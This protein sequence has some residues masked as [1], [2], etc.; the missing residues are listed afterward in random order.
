MFHFVHLSVKI[1]LG[2]G[3]CDFT[4]HSKKGGDN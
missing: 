1:N 2:G 4:K 3:L